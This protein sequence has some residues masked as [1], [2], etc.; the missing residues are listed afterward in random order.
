MERTLAR[1]REGLADFRAKARTP[2]ELMAV[3]AIEDMHRLIGK[4]IANF[5]AAY[6]VMDRR[7][8]KSQR[9]L[10]KRAGSKGKGRN[11]R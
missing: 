4:D 7:K 10:R 11:G 8:S 2:D 3:A 9:V 1:G 6:G 5:K